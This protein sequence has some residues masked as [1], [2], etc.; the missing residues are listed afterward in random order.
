L[1]RK[2]KPPVAYI[3]LL[4]KFWQTCAENMANNNTT[5]TRLLTLLNV[6]ATK[7]GKRKWAAYDDYSPVQKLN[8]RKNKSVKTVSVPGEI[9]QVSAPA[10]TTKDPEMEIGEG[11]WEVEEVSDDTVEGAF[12]NVLV[13]LINP[14]SLVDSSDPYELHFGCKPSCLSELSR[15]AVDGRRWKSVKTLSGRLGPTLESVPKGSEASSSKK[16]DNVSF[17]ICFNAVF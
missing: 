5:T 4:E 12:L 8:K 11:N 6:S 1:K 16:I 3:S 14:P 7:A 10:P 9:D 13:F 17:S 2:D 15:N